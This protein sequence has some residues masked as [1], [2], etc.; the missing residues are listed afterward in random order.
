VA[1]D[2]EIDTR[3][4][5]AQ[6]ATLMERIAQLQGLLREASDEQARAYLSALSFLPVADTAGQVFS[7]ASMA[8]PRVRYFSFNPRVRISAYPFGV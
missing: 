6:Q 7:C 5:R 2:A 3:V 1:A 8:Y 4:A